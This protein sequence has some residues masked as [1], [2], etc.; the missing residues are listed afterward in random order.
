[1]LLDESLPPNLEDPDH[2]L[3]HRNP[4]MDAVVLVLH[5]AETLVDATLLVLPS[6]PSQARSV[7]RNALKLGHLRSLCF[8]VA[9]S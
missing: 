3:V 7:A 4:T 2:R 6:A 8:L 5:P 1:M 9:R